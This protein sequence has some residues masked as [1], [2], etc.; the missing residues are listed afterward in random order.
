MPVL[1]TT[2][3]DA[4]FK[5]LSVYAFTPQDWADNVIRERARIA[6]EAIVQIAVAKCL[7]DGTQIPG[8]KEGIVDLA[9]RNEWVKAATAEEPGVF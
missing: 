6:I 1:S 2:I 8:T 3:T 4:E 7:E 9:F 5:A